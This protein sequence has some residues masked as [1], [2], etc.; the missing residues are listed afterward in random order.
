MSDSPHPTTPRRSPSEVSV[1][2]SGVEVARPGPDTDGL[3]VVQR[4]SS[5]E[6]PSSATEQACPAC[7]TTV[8]AH[9]Q[10]CHACGVPLSAL[11]RQESAERRVVTVLFGDLSDFTAWAEDLDPERVGEVTDRV[12][13]GLARTVTDF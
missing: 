2:S 5:G 13:A 12:L 9:A 3:S 10:F 11:P 7:G 4:V 1:S 6:T 8:V